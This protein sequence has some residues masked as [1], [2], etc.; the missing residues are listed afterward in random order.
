MTHSRTDR[1]LQIITQIRNKSVRLYIAPWFC[2]YGWASNLL[3]TLSCRSCRWNTHNQFIIRSHD[4]GSSAI[5]GGSR[6]FWEA[7]EARRV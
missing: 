4:I 2:R 3:V 1:L 6:H 5:F 7:K